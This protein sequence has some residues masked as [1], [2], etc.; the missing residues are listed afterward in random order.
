MSSQ[1]GVV[2]GLS[3][4]P[5]VSRLQPLASASIPPLSDDRPA[6]QPGHIGS[7]A[8]LLCHRPK[9]AGVP[10]RPAVHPGV[11]LEAHADAPPDL[12]SVWLD[13]ATGTNCTKAVLQRSGRKRM[14]RDAAC[15]R[16][17]GLRRCRR[18]GDPVQARL[19]QHIVAE[20]DAPGPATDNFGANC[21]MAGGASGAIGIE[22]DQAY[23][24]HSVAIA[25]Y[26]YNIPIRQA[27]GYRLRAVTPTRSSS[28]PGTTR[29]RT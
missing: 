29:R 9:S 14:W 8:V 23:A 24:R 2:I 13:T 26:R 25:V 28:A 4:R 27:S 16:Q 21:A 20:D 19:R 10:V 1:V 18:Y 12:E 15:R 5:E 11:E 6:V 22:L 7:G 17:P 3:F